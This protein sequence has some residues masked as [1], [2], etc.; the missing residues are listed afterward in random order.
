[1]EEDKLIKIEKSIRSYRAVAFACIVLGFLCIF[2][3]FYENQFVGPMKWN[4]IGDY[5]GGTMVGLWSLAGLFFIYVAFLGQRL[6]IQLT[7]KELEETRKV[8]SRNTTLINRQ[9]F[10]N[11]FFNL[12]QTHIQIVAD[13]D[14][15][16]QVINHLNQY[17]TTN[18][19]GRDVF[20]DAFIQYMQ[21]VKEG[22][23]RLEAY[24]KLY[25][26][27][28]GEFGHYYRFLYRLIDTVERKQFVEELDIKGKI[29]D[30]EY[31]KIKEKMNFDI[32]YEYTS[33]VR[34]LL[35]DDELELLFYNMLHFDELKFKRL[36]EKYVLLKNIPNGE[37]KISMTAYNFN[38][39]AIKKEENPHF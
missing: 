28:R 15:T 18:S 31:K 17:E 37:K 27:N 10:D 24:H 30:H 34:S 13:L 4:E 32:Q 1:M 25:N 26:A 20:R 23:D 3:V 19:Q 7:K 9:Q 5:L 6:D 21:P 16:F 14:A 22:A 33:I 38:P 2:V 29:P 39:G 36:I 11:L 35:S 8:H 12:I